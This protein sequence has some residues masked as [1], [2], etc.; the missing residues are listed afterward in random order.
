MATSIDDVARAAGVSTA[1][2]SR[3]LRGLPHVTPETRELVRRT[4]SRLGYV[5]SPSAAALASGRTRTVGLVAP[6]ISRWFFATAFEG[7]EHALR[8]ADFDALLYSIPDTR[9]PRARFDP[10]VLRRRV[11]AVIVSMFLGPDEVE[12]LRSLGLPVVFVSVRQPGFAHVGIDDDAAADQATRHLIGLGHRVI[13]HIGGAKRD[14][15]PYSPTARR[16]AG[17]R[18][19]LADAGLEHGDDLDEA[20]DFTAESGGRAAAALLDRRRD[21]TALFVASDEMAMGAIQAVRGRGLVIGRDI[22]VI[23]VDGHNL[24]GLMGLTTIA[25]PSYG[26]GARAARFLLDALGGDYDPAAA[27]FF[28]TTLVERES[29]GPAPLRRR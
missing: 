18:R 26:Q 14:D 3:A 5:P 16:R 20:G 12:G 6:A 23:G 7:A 28:E 17:W 13:G 1:T 2:V 8:A 11:D 21:L 22:S 19:T 10:A 9:Q 29:T 15:T 24:G 25:Q 4:A 27:I